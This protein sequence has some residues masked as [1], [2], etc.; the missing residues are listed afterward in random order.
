MSDL[1]GTVTTENGPK[2]KKWGR[3]WIFSDFVRKGVRAALALVL[4][5]FA[6]YLTGS[7]PDPGFSDRVLFLLLRL[8]RYA[9][10]ILSAFSLCALGFNVR[11]LVYHPNVR[12]ALGLCFYF[13]TGIFGAGF[14]MLNSMIISVA[15]GNG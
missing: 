3:R 12:N 7:M 10:L 1:T 15:G 2:W 8:L 14:A 6:V 9:S 13:L 11:R 5:I 4:L